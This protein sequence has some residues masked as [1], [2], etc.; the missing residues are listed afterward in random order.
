[1]NLK[2]QP[3][4]EYLGSKVH[5]SYI[6]SIG[7]GK[8]VVRV[9]KRDV[10]LNNGSTF[11]YIPSNNP[12]IFY[13]GYLYQM[14]DQRKLRSFARVRF[15]DPVLRGLL[16]GKPRGEILE[17]FSRRE[18]RYYFC[19]ASKNSSIPTDELAKLYPTFS[20]EDIVV[21]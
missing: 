9:L 17:K 18:G 5:V 10:H 15:K 2:N 21:S 6:R 19:K 7:H 12:S 20:I 13:C 1:M 3:K 16:D 8:K 14:E 11:V 4:I